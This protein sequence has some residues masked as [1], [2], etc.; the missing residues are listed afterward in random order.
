MQ[1]IYTNLYV[2]FMIKWM[3][4]FLVIPEDVGQIDC[5]PQ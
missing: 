1:L 4:Q 5:L 3:T 2:F